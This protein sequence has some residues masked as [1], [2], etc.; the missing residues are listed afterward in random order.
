MIENR[1]VGGQAGDRQLVD[2]APEKARPQHAAREVV[3]PEA[4][5][6]I[7]QNLCRFHGVASR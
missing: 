1:R 2:V 6:E 5:A 7:A 4:L 3:K